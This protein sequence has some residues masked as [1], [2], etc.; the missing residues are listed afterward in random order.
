MSEATMH[1]TIR[2]NTEERLAAP[3]RGDRAWKD[4]VRNR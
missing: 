1:F 3:D 2:L 4:E